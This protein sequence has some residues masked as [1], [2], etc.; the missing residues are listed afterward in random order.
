MKYTLLLLFFFS[1]ALAFAHSPAA[2]K[3]QALNLKPLE[4][5]QADRSDSSYLKLQ[6]E[7]VDALTNAVAEAV[8]NPQDEILIDEIFR[9]SI[10]LLNT[11]P[12]QY[13]GE[14]LVPLYQKQQNLFLKHLKKF[15]T[16][17]AQRIKE[18]VKA[19]E[20]TLRRGNG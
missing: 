14:I 15:S 4:Q 18:A 5:T 13:A 2:S 16:K 9:V 1:Q 6:D 19:A 11:D 7:A 20:R 17:D 10:V 3:L 12:Y 8:K